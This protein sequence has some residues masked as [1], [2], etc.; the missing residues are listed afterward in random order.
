MENSNAPPGGFQLLGGV[1]VP[2]HSSE[3][4]AGYGDPALQIQ[5]HDP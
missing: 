1:A 5:L 2:R 3:D 4:E